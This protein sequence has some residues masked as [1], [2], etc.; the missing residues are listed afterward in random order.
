MLFED[1]FLSAGLVEEERLETSSQLP[2]R[3]LVVL[4]LGEAFHFAPPLVLLPLHWTESGTQY[5][6]H[7]SETLDEIRIQKS[8]ARFDRKPTLDHLASQWCMI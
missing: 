2:V 4:A 3:F 7:V 1:L 6:I 5:K 8:H